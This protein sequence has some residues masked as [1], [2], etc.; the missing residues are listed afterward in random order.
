[1]GLA[2]EPGIEDTP[3]VGSVGSHAGSRG[4]VLMLGKP[5]GSEGS[6]FRQI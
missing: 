3:G 1:M 6:Q 2:L 5:P 4:M